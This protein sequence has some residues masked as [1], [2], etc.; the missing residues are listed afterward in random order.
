MG[1]NRLRVVAHIRA[2]PETVDEVRALLSGLVDPTR[3]E[4]GCIT[5]DLLQNHEDPTDFTFVEEWTGADAL[6]AHFETAHMVETLPKLQAV[7]AAPPDI[8]RY[9]LVR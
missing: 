1:E 4:P 5:Y 9:A 8:R 3:R 2:K 7:A 6:A